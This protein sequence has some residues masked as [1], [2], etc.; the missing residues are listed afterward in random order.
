MKGAYLTISGRIRRELQELEQIAER[1]MRIWQKAALS[2]DDYYIDATAFNLH[3]L[4]AGIERIFEVI[5]DGI[6]LVKPDGANWHH[7]LLHQMTAEI[8]GI[9]PPVMSPEVRDKLDR[10]RGF[11]HVVRNVYTFKLDPQQMDVLVK[12]LKP[13]ME[14]VSQELLAFADFLERIAAED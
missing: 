3:S 9:R 10:Y 14:Q 13:T 1:T 6:D 2:A 5:A 11:R 4:Y 8:P 7:E 12:N